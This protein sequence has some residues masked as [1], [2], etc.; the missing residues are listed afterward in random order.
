VVRSKRWWWPVF[1]FCVEDRHPQRLAGL[2]QDK[3]KEKNLLYYLEFRQS[4]VKT[5]LIKHADK[6]KNAGRPKSG[7]SVEK[8]VPDAVRFD[9]LHH[10]CTPAPRQ[11]RCAY[12]HKNTK[13]MC[14][15]CPNKLARRTV[16]Q[17]IP[18]PMN[19]N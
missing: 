15:K 14:E 5:Y 8:K 12:C 17:S 11:N 1:V 10:W 13:K 6:P 9:G 4:I 7:Q 19:R 2:S 18:Q 16:L 3:S